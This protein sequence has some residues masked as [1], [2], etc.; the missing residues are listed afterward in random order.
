M[1]ALE[2]Q[3]RTTPRLSSTMHLETPN[4]RII[5]V[6]SRDKYGSRSFAETLT[7]VVGVN[8]ELTLRPGN[9]TPVDGLSPGVRIAWGNLAGIQGVCRGAHE[10]SVNVVTAG[11]TVGVEV[12]RPRA[13]HMFVFVAFEGRCDEFGGG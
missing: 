7:I 11:K 1:A 3:G 4:L 10:G 12:H 13:S 2:F 6:F 8:S 9:I 5:T